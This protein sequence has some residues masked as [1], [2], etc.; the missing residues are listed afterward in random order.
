MKLIAGLVLAVACGAQA[1]FEILDGKTT[2]SLRGIDA[3]SPLVAWASG[4]GG[5]VLLTTDGGANWKHCAVP[6]DGEKLDFRGVRGRD[7]NVALVMASGAGTASAVYKTTDGCATWRRVF[8]N[9]DPDGFFDALV[10]SKIGLRYGLMGDQVGGRFTVFWSNDRGET[11]DRDTTPGLE[12]VK[13]AGGFAASNSGFILPIEVKEGALLEFATSATDTES[14]MF[15]SSFGPRWVKVPV[16]MP[17]N[18]GTSGVFS[19]D[20]NGSSVV[21][22]GVNYPKPN[23]TAGTAAYSV[24]LGKH[25]QASDTMPSGYRSAV[26]FDPASKAWIAVGPNG[27]DI[28]RDHGRHWKPLKPSTKDAPEADKNWNAISLPFVVGS[29]GK[30]GKLKSGVLAK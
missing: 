24:D 17:V 2:A 6:P 5:T 8:A 25:W 27:T 21:A 29:K 14:P 12:A 28:S 7:Q 15:Y 22:V 13:G 16:P 3:V 1:Q 10:Q 26:A 4:S 11:W 18:G 23:D 9:P 30:I 20:T 19:L